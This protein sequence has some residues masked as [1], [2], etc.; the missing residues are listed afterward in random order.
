LRVERSAI[1]NQILNR[2]FQAWLKEYKLITGIHCGD[3]LEHS[4]FW[5]GFEHVDPGKEANAIDIKLKNGTTT[6]AAEYAKQG[7][8]WEAEFQQAAKERQ[9]M[10]ELGLSFEHLDLNMENEES[11]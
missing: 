9:R 5:D 2:I 6:Y 8:D 3:D 4:W 11:E 1:E 7:R 10:A